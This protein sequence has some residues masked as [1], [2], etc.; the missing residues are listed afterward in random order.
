MGVDNS[1]IPR[2]D[3][4]VMSRG[5]GIYKLESG[6][7]KTSV[8][9]PQ[10]RQVWR[11]FGTKTEA[12]AWRADASVSKSRGE[13]VDPRSGSVTLETVYA[14]L[15][16]SRSYAP[17]TL[18]KHGELWKRL[19]PDLGHR[20]IGT[21][22]VAL[23][24][25]VLGKIERPIMRES[26]RLLLSAIFGHASLTRGRIVNPAKRKAVPSTRASRK[27]DG[28]RRKAPKRYLRTDELSRL[29]SEVP[30]RHRALVHL[31]ARV[32][33]RPGEAYALRVGKLDPLKRTLL[34]DTAASGDT[35]TGEARTLVLP[36]SVAQELTEHVERWSTW[37]RDALIFPGPQGAMIRGENFRNRVL[38]PAAERAGIKGLRVND[39]RHSAVSFA[40]NEAGANVYD[41]QRMV[42]HAKASITL[43]VYGEL[44]DT[45]QERLA[46]RLDEAIRAE[47]AAMAA[48]VASLGRVVS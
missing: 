16:A 20:P 25:R 30:E 47:P 31:M 45:S 46:E 13:Y 29:L 44:W 32:G 28:G 43:D 26:A 33:L 35:K 9:D 27:S 19:G 2:Q 34:V 40:I 23:V 7:Y 21:I 18:A 14:E 3:G 17:A 48:T 42:G 39:L 38:G 5:D 6:R 4:S 37:D 15:H 11:T 36:A 1:R 8:R 10:G 24:D 12:R 22:D 41:V